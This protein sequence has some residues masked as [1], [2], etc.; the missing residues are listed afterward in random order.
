M[1]NYPTNRRTCRV[2]RLKSEGVHEEVH[3]NGVAASRPV[4]ADSGELYTQR[5]SIKVKL[6]SGQCALCQRTRVRQQG[7]RKHC[8]GYLPRPRQ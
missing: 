5:A 7:Q 2:A 6:T 1:C 8:A 3:K 4:D